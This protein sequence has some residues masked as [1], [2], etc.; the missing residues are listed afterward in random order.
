MKKKQ[1]LASMMA[2]M[3]L[4][5]SAMPVYAD[6][7]A[8][9]GDTGSA[10]TNVSFT[11]TSSQLGG[12]VVS[13]PET[14]VLSY[15]DSTQKFSSSDSVYAYGQLGS[16]LQLE[17]SSPATV[18]YSNQD[19][20]GASQLTGTVEFVDDTYT[21]Y[22]SSE[23]LYAGVADD[24]SA[25]KK[26]TLKCVVNE[27]NGIQV[28]TYKGEVNF[29][30]KVSKDLSK[31]V[32][33]DTGSG[34]SIKGTNYAWN[35]DV[36]KLTSGT[37]G[38]VYMN[39]TKA[40]TWLAD[41]A[42]T[43]LVIPSSKALGSD[44]DEFITKNVGGT[45]GTKTN[46]IDTVIFP[47]AIANT[48]KGLTIECKVNDGD[49]ENTQ[50]TTIYMPAVKSIMRFTIRKLPNLTDVYYAGSATE[51]ENA[52]LSS[53]YN[54]KDGRYDNDSLWNATIRVLD[55]SDNWIDFDKNAFFVDHPKA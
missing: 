49:N 1:F 26:E 21:G 41:S 9:E 28:G 40:D 18:K 24:H 51:F 6:G 53:N 19:V 43:T 20:A 27:T 14:L 39:D 13:V 32:Y 48:S 31:S 7:L 52:I 38:D 17:I 12:V 15:D 8:E 5:S 54:G 29:T 3:M 34:V 25:S 10:Q 23:Q 50:I 44:S 35:T 2:V 33:Y 45:L 47:A 42:N 55:E 11:T 30:I 37:N 36:F 16:K 46:H 22:W 4:A